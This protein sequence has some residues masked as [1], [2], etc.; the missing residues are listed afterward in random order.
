MLQSPAKIIPVFYGVEPCTLRHIE[1]GTYAKT[2]IGY[3]QK[4]RH[5]DKLQQWKEALQSIS[6]TTGYEI[7]DSNVGD[8]ESILSAVQREVQRIKPLQVARYPVALDKLVQ[9][10]EIHCG[11]NKQE[12][13]KAKFIGIFGMGGLGKT[14]LAKELFN[15]NRQQYDRACFLFDVREAAARCNLA[16]LQMRLLKDLFN[17]KDIS[18][19]SI[20][21]G[22]NC[23]CNSIE[24]SPSLSF[25][26]V[27][28]DIDHVEQLDALSISHMLKRSSNSLVIITTRDVGILIAE[29]IKV[30]Y[31][32]K[33]M[34]K[35]DARQ[36]FSWHAFSQPYPTDGY[37]DLV[38]DFLGVC[39]G[40]PLSLK[41]LGR[42]V[43]GRDDNYWKSELH[44]L[45]KTMHRD[46]RKSLKISFDALER[47]EKQIFMDV[48]CFFVNQLKRIPIRV[49]KASGWSDQNGLQSLKDK[50]LVEEI[51]DP[52]PVLRMHDLLRDLGREMANELSQPPRL[53]RPEDL[54]KLESKGF[55]NI[56]AQT[57]GRCF[58]SIF[59]MSLN[60][61]DKF[62]L[63]KLDDNAETSS[64]LLWL[65]LRYSTIYFE[66]Y[67]FNLNSLRHPHD[68]S[69]SV[70]P[71]IPPWVPLKNIQCL[72]IS[73]GYFK[74][75]W[76]QDAEAPSEIK[77]LEIDGT[78]IEEYTDYLGILTNVEKQ[79]NEGQHMSKMKSLIVKTRR[80]LSKSLSKNSHRKS[81][82]VKAPL[83]FIENLA[84]KEQEN[85]ERIEI[86]GNYCPCLQS[87]ELSSVGNLIEVQFTRVE[88]LNCFNISN[89]QYLKSLSVTSDLTKLEEL[90]I[91]T[92]PMLE[93]PNLGNLS[94][95]KK[96]RIT[97]CDMNI[98]PGISSFKM[99]VELNVHGCPKLRELSLE[100]LSCLEKII[101]ECCDRLQNV[102][103][104]SHL[105]KLVEVSISLCWTLQL[106]LC[107]ADLK[108]L[109]RITVDSSVKVKVFDLIGCRSLH[110]LSGISFEMIRV[111]NICGCPE[112]KNLPV[113][114]GP[115]CLE[116][117]IINECGQLNNLKLTD[118]KNL[119][120][121]ACNFDLQGLSIS[122]CPMLQ[123]LPSFGRVNHLEEIS[124]VQCGSLQNMT[125]PMTL[126]RL[127]LNACGEL[128]T[129]LGISG[130]TKLEELNI[131]RCSQ[132]RLEWNFSSCNFLKS[133]TTVECCNVYHISLP[134]TLNELT[135][136]RCMEFQ[137]IAATVSLP[138]LTYL[139]ISDCEKLEMLP[140]LDALSYLTI[141][142]C[143]KLHNISL[144]TTLI[145]ITLQRCSKLQ[146]VAGMA[147]L[148][149]L[150]E[151]NI[152]ECPEIELPAFCGLSCLE[153]ITIDG[154]KK[155][156]S[157]HLF[158]CAILKAVR[159]NF[160]L[161]HVSQLRIS[162]CPE[163]EEL[164]CLARLTSLEE[165]HIFRCG[166]LHKVT[167]P[168]TLKNL[169]LNS[170]K[171]LKRVS[172][173]SGLASLKDLIISNCGQLELDLRLEDMDSLQTI[174]FDCCSKIK[175]F[176]LNNCQNLKRVSG[177][178][179][180]DSI[181]ICGCHELEE[182]SISDCPG[183]SCVE[184]IYI[185]SCDKLQNITLPT[186]L[187][188]LKIQL[189]R[190]L[191]RVAISAF[192][193]VGRL[194]VL[195]RLS[196]LKSITIDSCEKLKNIEGVQDLQALEII[197]LL[198]CSYAAINDCIPK[199][200]RMPSAF[201]QVVG[202]AAEGAESNLNPSLIS[203]AYLY[204]SDIWHSMSAIIICS[205][206]VVDVN[207]SV[208]DNTIN[209]SLEDSTWKFNLRQGEWIITTIITH[210]NYRLLYKQFD[211]LS[212][213]GIMKKWCA[214]GVN[215]CEDWRICHALTTIID[216]L[217]QK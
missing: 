14:T 25:L 112:L 193:E 173:I 107:L 140:D 81:S 146:K 99:L 129:L 72:T 153:R 115:S 168:R 184:K 24:R 159:G 104:L 10:F 160:D 178:F 132:L 33:G 211:N 67:A 76:Q 75:L 102:A 216:E 6:F 50:C 163:L 18:F 143:Q 152:S 150:A 53:W 30:G 105:L 179:D 80:K 128:K 49:W 103:G 1:N 155:F 61:E 26:S 214:W 207:N 90:S 21:E 62:F 94:C 42:H 199:L 87:L 83:S 51:E 139:Y 16:E 54:K 8:L 195:A 63:G 158:D 109:K 133:I 124:I 198:Y 121:V 85:I 138:K 205:V 86:N 130:L 191:Q 56:F 187:I 43:H 64:C 174:I 123:E 154:C 69:S 12:E 176:L 161:G 215:K 166:K 201:I 111:L 60:Y 217:H 192:P 91:S 164:P 68:K 44:K 15:R 77:E 22:S 136:Q 40:L 156:N 197:Q 98:V 126:K 5:L 7:N 11:M 93:E 148:T 151:L 200:K 118:C 35:D 47:E 58:H 142:S 144:P 157:L 84:I 3:Q 27:L 82:T 181:S 29:G 177:N 183:L 171:E 92:C 167:L 31:H 28:D 162:D 172:E 32:L 4:S 101:V 204:Q 52:V 113:I 206:V 34:D 37:E 185:E 131:K 117:I 23:F 78:F 127:E 212:K 17:V 39:G 141:D 203:E 149:K 186:T 202:R 134:A 73:N 114:C 208:P 137:M 210:Q 169:Q 20:E 165:I 175:S 48:A 213:Q 79:V 147:D 88:T 66:P 38:D 209:E 110:T 71:T 46:I 122:D 65:H 70:Q 108:S 119:K 188:E 2:F 19:Q 135:V 36:L 100:H 120:R 59:D 125:L 55:E 145:K 74:R 13:G 170:C 189:C 196:C 182:L 9:D 97:K 116:L 180:V 96:I 45:G 57:N 106:E 194:S 95:L 190:E 41:V 89:C